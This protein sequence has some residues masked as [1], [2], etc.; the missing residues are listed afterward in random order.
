MSPVSCSLSLC[1]TLRV[2]V[3]R[4]DTKMNSVP[5]EQAWAQLS[6][7]GIGFRYNEPWYDEVFIDN[8]TIHRVI[9]Y[10][11]QKQCL[12]FPQAL[13]FKDSVEALAILQRLEIPIKQLY[14][15]DK[16]NLKRWHDN[17]RRGPSKLLLNS[18]L[19]EIKVV[20]S[21]TRILTFSATT[22]T[23]YMKTLLMWAKTQNLPI[24]QCQVEL[25][26]MLVE[27]LYRV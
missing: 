14:L 19:A 15:R 21:P 18:T 2:R 22:E 16:I 17:G 11:P 4:C 9:L 13:G 5:L 25:L 3:T 27:L 12:I 7:L 10:Y 24:S 23:T 8:L 1:D 20:I 6:D 26:G